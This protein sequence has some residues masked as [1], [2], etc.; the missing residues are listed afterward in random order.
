M[1][2]NNSWQELSFYFEK[3]PEEFQWLVNNYPILQ[4]QNKI[5]DFI[6]YFFAKIN[7]ASSLNKFTYSVDNGLYFSENFKT[8]EAVSIPEFKI[9]LGKGVEIEA[10]ACIKKNCIIFDNSEIRHTAYLRGNVLVASHCTIGHATEIKNSIVFTHSEIGHFNYVGDSIIGSY[11]NLGAGSILCNLPFRTL[12]QKKQQKFPEFSLGI[13]DKNIITA[14]KK[15]VILGDGCETGCN[16]VIGPMSFLGQSCL[17][18]PN[19]Y[20]SKGIYPNKTNFKTSQDYKKLDLI[21]KHD[22]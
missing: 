2:K 10:G 13:A 22:L 12:Q 3:V 11:C 19:V 7:L 6:N 14:S 20:I 8:K 4:W 5:S 21:K 17:I 18:Y 9:Y 15:G 16:S 1:E